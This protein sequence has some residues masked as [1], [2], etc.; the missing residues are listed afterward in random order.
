MST[1]ALN[2]FDD[3]TRS[4]RDRTR[5]SI[6]YAAACL[7]RDRGYAAATLRDIADA[8]RMKAGSIYYHFNSK[9]EILIEILDQGVGKMHDAV[10]DAVVKCGKDGGYEARIGAAVYAHLSELLVRSDFISAN[11][12]IYSQLPESIREKHRPA[13]RRFSDLWEELLRQ[14]Q[15]AGAIR[16]DI[17]I[18]PLRQ[19][20]VGALNWSVEW[21]DE[22]QFPIDVF[23]DRATRVILNGIMRHHGTGT[24]GYLDGADVLPA[25]AQEMRRKSDRTRYEI[26]RAAACLFRDK[27]YGAATLRDI[28]TVTR[29]KAGS[30]YYHFNSKDEILDE[31]LDMGLRDI[32]EGVQASLAALGSDADQRT[33]IATLVHAHLRLLLARSEFTSANIRIYGQ[34]P[35]EI[36]ARHR[37]LRQAYVAVWED[38]LREAR[39]AGALRAD[40]SIVPLRQFLLG[41]LNWTVEWYEPSRHSVDALAE[42]CTRIIL[43]G[44]AVR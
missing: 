36:R 4:K 21:Y 2:Q 13:R 38:V 22:E 12:R 31:V 26:L 29:M 25:P 10:R 39:D 32:H 23:A 41:A 16:P 33:R 30:I 24:V 17:K 34:L 1:T 11:I 43:D 14:A 5:Q 28:A 18:R 15:A 19:F 9:D 3:S 35:E 27:G 40:V 8:A 7:F 44:I 6:L 20:L 42:R 37:P